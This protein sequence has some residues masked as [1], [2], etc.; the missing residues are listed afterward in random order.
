[1][2]YSASVGIELPCRSWL[3]PGLDFDL[4]Q[5]KYN[6]LHASKTMW[7]ISLTFRR[8]LL[9]STR[10][11]FARPGIAL[12]YGRLESLPYIHRD[13]AMFIVRG[14]VEVDIVSRSHVGWSAE[15]GVVAV[16]YGKVVGEGGSS[17]TA[18]VRPII[19]VGVLFK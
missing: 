12:G 13:A 10:G 18:D 4:H 5:A 3:A 7:A 2:G 19:R 15:F 9:P 8:A 6:R 16:P 11:P 14:S 17:F 1:M